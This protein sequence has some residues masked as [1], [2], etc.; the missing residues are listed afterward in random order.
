[1]KSS[2]VNS[3]VNDQFCHVSDLYNLSGF[4]GLLIIYPDSDSADFSDFLR[5]FL[6]SLVEYNSKLA[7]VWCFNYLNWY[8]VVDELTSSSY[9]FM[10]LFLSLITSVY[11]FSYQLMPRTTKNWYWEEREF[12]GRKYF[13]TSNSLSKFQTY[14]KFHKS[15]I[16]NSYPYS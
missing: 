2:F 10:T 12:K 13:S 14:R 8:R 5:W 6:S 9:L 11:F 16:F 1:M 15:L 3:F 4:N 7:S